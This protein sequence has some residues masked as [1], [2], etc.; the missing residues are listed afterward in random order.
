MLKRALLLTL[1]A[2]CCLAQ[3][4]WSW[5]VAGMLQTEQTAFD[6]RL[7]LNSPDGNT[8]AF[9]TYGGYALFNI[10]EQA[11]KWLSLA[12]QNG[13][14]SPDLNFAYGN[15]PG[16][17]ELWRP[18][19]TRWTSWTR[20]A[21]SGEPFKERKNDQYILAMDAAGNLITTRT[22]V[23][24]EGDKK[25]V[26]DMQ[27]LFVVDRKTGKTIK[28]LRNDVLYH[29][30][31][32]TQFIQFY[33]N[34]SMDALLVQT[35]LDAKLK[36]VYPFDS[37]DVIQLQ[38]G[39]LDNPNLE[40]GEKY[41]FTKG[42]F[43]YGTATSYLGIHDLRKGG[44]EILSQSY[45]SRLTYQPAL[46][47]PM[48]FGFH[49]DHIF[50]FERENTYKE[51]NMV[52]EEA[53]E[54]G[55]LKTVNQWKVDMR[56]ESPGSS[57]KYGMT[58][59]KGPT[60]LIYPISRSAADKSSSANR[61]FLIDLPS[62]KLVRYIHPFFNPNAETLAQEA[63]FKAANEEYAANQKKAADD[64]VAAA[65]KANWTDKGYQRGRT[66]FFGASYVIMD[67]YDP[68]KD[69][70]KLWRP[71]Q[72]YEGNGYIMPAESM[73][74][75]GYGW[76]DKDYSTAKQYRKCGECEGDGH[77]EYTEYTTKT[78]ELP[79]GYFSGI[80]T[81]RISTT[82]TNKSRICNECSGQGVILK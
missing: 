56:G 11:F 81:K 61:A 58:V 10:P 14:L 20:G 6:H 77:I 42:G 54:N 25:Y 47:E 17:G 5:P 24:T 26:G 66:Y 45:P 78:K 51:P 82:A 22:S 57:Q 68:A 37:T 35:D 63:R 27:G 79:W 73:I 9:G 62:Q 12:P 23:V 76:R 43:N 29:R 21:L 50:R 1:L 52:F 49:R 74:V 32:V 30:T 16:N 31:Q 72:R 69:Q 41:V 2:S 64:K 71:Q 34:T 80:E 46:Y 75:P 65:I 13:R 4:N 33:F 48:I 19:S 60:L 70:Y 7:A 3:D 67:A 28:T 18:V 59:G 44:G 53:I 8:V 55:V 38:C 36:Q 15:E 40:I 39:R